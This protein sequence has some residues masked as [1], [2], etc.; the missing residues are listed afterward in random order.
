MAEKKIHL[1][2]PVEYDL[3]I[4]RPGKCE[5]DVTNDSKMYYIKTRDKTQLLS[6]MNRGEKTEA[7]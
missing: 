7:I 6:S 2:P 1:V 3:L 5:T 4:C